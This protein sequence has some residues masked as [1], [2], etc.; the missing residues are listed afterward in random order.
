MWC[1]SV[2]QS[3]PALSQKESRKK[4]V[5]PRQDSLQRCPQLAQHW[6]PAQNGQE[7]AQITQER[8]K[9]RETLQKV[10]QDK[11]NIKKRL[12]QLQLQV[13]IYLSHQHCVLLLLLCKTWPVSENVGIDE[14]DQTLVMLTQPSSSNVYSL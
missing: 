14:S 13:G 12:E 7:L 10:E 11:A 6:Q 4:S 8:N 3:L 1:W 5:T 9:L 2:L